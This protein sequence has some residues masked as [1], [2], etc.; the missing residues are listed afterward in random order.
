MEHGQEFLKLLEIPKEYGQQLEGL[1]QNMANVKR[2]V[3][4]TKSLLLQTQKDIQQIHL[5]CVLNKLV[6]RRLKEIELKLGQYETASLA[7][8]NHLYLDCAQN[9]PTFTGTSVLENTLTARAE[10]LKLRFLHQAIEE[11]RMFL[12]FTPRLTLPTA[13]MF[14][15]RVD[16]RE[17]IFN[18]ALH[19]PFF[20]RYQ[21][22]KRARCE[23]YL[24][25]IWSL[26]ALEEKTG[27]VA[28]IH[29]IL[30][31]IMRIGKAT[32]IT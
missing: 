17:E 24:S 29:D 4:E 9:L 27:R 13:H 31:G 14:F 12:Y 8:K 15:E 21:L 25:S 7:L 28:V 5:N 32:E 20:K 18:E 16:D 2:K 3:K 22:F 23:E 11:V 6:Y 19:E 26:E 10:N 1:K 30:K